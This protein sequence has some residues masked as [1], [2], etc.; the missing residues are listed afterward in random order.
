[1][2]GDKRLDENSTVPWAKRASRRASPSVDHSDHD[3]DGE[4]KQEESIMVENSSPGSGNGNEHE[5]EGSRQTPSHNFLSMSL[6]TSL[7]EV[8]V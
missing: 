3:T 5:I 2:T 4:G 7:M 8:K 6:H 1:M